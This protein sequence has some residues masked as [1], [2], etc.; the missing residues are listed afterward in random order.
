MGWVVSIGRLFGVSSAGERDEAGIASMIDF[1]GL[2]G[3][4]HKNNVSEWEFLA[5]RAELASSSFEDS[6]NKLSATIF[7]LNVS[8]V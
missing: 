7:M 6:E 2:E 4:I 5:D 1:T 8:Q 3:G